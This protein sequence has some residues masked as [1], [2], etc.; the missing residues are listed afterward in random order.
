MP[1]TKGVVPDRRAPDDEAW[2]KYRLLVLDKLGVLLQSQ[3]E[4]D[5]RIT[6]I[7]RRTTKQWAFLAGAYAL[8][9][10]ALAIY[11]VMK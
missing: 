1:A 9:V 6:A 4:Q 3:K 5:E 2:P 7:D 8:L 10:L 11:G